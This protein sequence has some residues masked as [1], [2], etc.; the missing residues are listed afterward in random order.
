[1]ESEYS[2]QFQGFTAI[3]QINSCLVNVHHAFLLFHFTLL[4]VVTH[5]SSGCALPSQSTHTPVCITN[6]SISS[7]QPPRP[8]TTPQDQS[9]N[10]ST[11]L[12]SLVSPK[13]C[14]LLFRA[15]WDLRQ[16]TF[17]YQ[18]LA[19]LQSGWLVMT[20]TNLPPKNPAMSLFAT[21]QRSGQLHLV[22][23]EP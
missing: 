14:R 6:C 11:A 1:M 23:L 12:L 10:S 13:A 19:T 4:L 18:S 3:Y 16:P 2:V 22:H 8:P 21:V 5:G 15:I 7:Y 17:Q 9:R 20:T